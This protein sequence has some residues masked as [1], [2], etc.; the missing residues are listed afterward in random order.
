[1]EA[2]DG[3]RRVIALGFSR[4]APVPLLLIVLAMTGCG[5]IGPKT[6]IKDRFDYT[7][8][9]G[10]SWKSQMLLNLVKIR[11]GDAP[12]FLDI[13][14]I[15]AARSLL[16]SA[17]ATGTLFKFFDGPPQYAVTGSASATATGSY[18]DTPT[19]TYAPL[20]GERFA[21]QLMSPLPPAAILN[22]IQAGFPVDAVFRFGVQ[23]VNGIDNRRV[24]LQQVKPADPQFYALL[25]ELRLIQGSGD[26]GARSQRTDK[27]ETLTLVLRPKPSAVVERAFLNVANLL[28]LDPTARE[29]RVVYGAVATSDKEIAIQSRSILEILTDLS[30]YITVPEVHVAERRVGPTPEADQGPDGPIPPLIQIASSASRPDEAFVAVPYRGY[31]YSIDDRDMRSKS[32][33]SF[34]MFLFTFVETGSKEA[35]PVL[36]IPTR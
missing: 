30:A 36:T 15:V 9:V 1:M 10:D 22:V 34:I 17:S 6:V 33:F 3:Q 23:S 11:Y 26:I 4:I 14:Q 7:G 31:W 19:I 28:G 32:L 12:V 29:F 8:A 13:G 25:K 35:A 20:A 5:S 16:G 27:E 21:R 18:A 24:L 2:P